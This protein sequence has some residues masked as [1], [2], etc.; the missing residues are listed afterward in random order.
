MREV[1]EG[2]QVRP[3]VPFMQVVNPDT[4]EVRARANQ[5]DIPFLRTGQPVQ[6]RLDAYADLVFTGTLDQN[7]S[8]RTSERNVG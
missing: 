7:R 3:G 2:D 1:Q 8:H 5:A 6:L 4:M